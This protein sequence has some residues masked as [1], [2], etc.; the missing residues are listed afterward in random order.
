MK[1]PFI[2]LKAQYDSIREEI[3][4]ALNKVLESTA[5]SGGPFVAQFEKEFAAYCGCKH[6]VGV[7]S[8]TDALWVTLLAL[9][10]GPGNEVITVPNSFI[11]T[12]EAI[13]YCGARPVFV[14]ID[15]ST[16]NMD[17]N[18]LEDY[19]KKRFA[20]YAMRSA[21]RPKAVIPVHLFGQSADMDSIM[22]ITQKYG[23]FVVEDACQAHGA[24]YLSRRE[25]YNPPPTPLWKRD[26]PP[27]SPF[28][29][30]GLEGD[31]K[32]VMGGF[33]NEGRWRKAGTIGNAGCFSFYPGKN[34]GA[35]GEAG[36]V[37][38]ND[39]TLTEKIKVLRDHGQPVKYCHD[40][41]GWNA[42]MDGFQGA[43]LG[44]KLRYLDEWN[45]S[46]R[47]NARRYNNLLSSIEGI[48]TPEEAEYA[49]HVYHLYAIRTQNRDGL[50]RNLTEKNISCGIHYPL[51]IHLQKAYEFLGLKKGAFPVSEKYARELVSLPMYPE[52]TEEQ[53]AYVVE[54]IKEFALIHR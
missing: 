17:P 14:D 28:I 27:K 53:I 36:A 1:V 52:L 29:K 54:G 10:I 18:K 40:C 42:R 22:E 23:L 37:V 34:L 46:R 41:I 50:I 6:A 8:G 47:H 49:K 15:K 30:G 7:G 35:Y 44:V 9:G 11:A 48:Q 16:Y 45:E 51:P 32:G 25:T 19:V 21:P 33:S 39:D 24:E 13:S 2:D 5:F 38:T 12:A 20:S 43:V 26:N 3:Q 4:N 31:F